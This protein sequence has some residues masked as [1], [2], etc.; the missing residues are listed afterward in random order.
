[1]MIRVYSSNSIKLYIASI[2]E[3][4]LDIYEDKTWNSKIITKTNGIYNSMINT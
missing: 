1:M 2:L 4:R 3:T